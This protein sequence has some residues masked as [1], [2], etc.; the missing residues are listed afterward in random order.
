MMYYITDTI[1]DSYRVGFGNLFSF[2]FPCVLWVSALLN[3]P[4][5]YLICHRMAI[6]FS[7]KFLPFSPNNPESLCP[8]FYF[9]DTK[10][11]YIKPFTNYQQVY[12]IHIYFKFHA[13]FPSHIYFFTSIS[14]RK[15]GIWAKE[16]SF[17]A[18]S[19]GYSMS[20]STNTL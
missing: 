12:R 17:D 5:L 16:S 8:F 3:P 20:C 4:L 19:F 15:Y 1:W 7:P 18:F 2:L 9:P 14:C 10:L 13:F 11:I 6:P